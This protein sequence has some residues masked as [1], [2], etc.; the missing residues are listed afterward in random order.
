MLRAPLSQ[1]TPRAKFPATSVL[2]TPIRPPATIRWLLHLGGTS[3]PIA[4]DET[5]IKA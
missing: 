5:S 1:G 3:R 2:M 4:I